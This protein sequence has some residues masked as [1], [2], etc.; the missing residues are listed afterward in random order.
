M[1]YKEFKK[2]CNKRASEGTW[3]TLQARYCI[4]IM[5][6]INTYPFW[7]REKTWKE[8]YEYITYLQVIK[9]IEKI[10]KGEQNEN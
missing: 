4:D 2:W 3:G 5:C 9:P 7:K 6:Y 8:E 10:L 1:T